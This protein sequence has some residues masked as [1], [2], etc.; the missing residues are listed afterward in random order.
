MF[1]CSYCLW[2]RYIQTGT[3]LVWHLSGACNH[4]YC[5]IWNLCV[6][7]H[8]GVPFCGEVCMPVLAGKISMGS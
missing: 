3:S 4:G 8:V 6:Q 1:P 5:S 2:R 7:L